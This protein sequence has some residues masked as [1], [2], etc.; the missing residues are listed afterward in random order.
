MSWRSR[1][2]RLSAEEALSL[3]LVTRVVDDGDLR[4]ATLALARE[5]AAAPRAA[6]VRSMAMAI[7]GAK[8]AEQASFGW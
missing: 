1:T 2:A 6:L 3:R 4:D 8:V 7:A 5:V